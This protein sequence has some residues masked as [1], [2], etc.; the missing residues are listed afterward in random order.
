MSANIMSAGTQLSPEQ[1]TSL[2]YVT[3]DVPGTLGIVA[4]PNISK[5]ESAEAVPQGTVICVRSDAQLDVSLLPPRMFS[6]MALYPIISAK[7]DT[8]LDDAYFR[9]RMSG[10]AGRRIAAGFGAGP[11]LANTQLDGIGVPRGADRT[12]WKPLLG[13]GF[14]SVCKF[15]KE[16]YDS[17][18]YIAVYVPKTQLSDEFV[19]LANEIAQA[20]AHNL[21][22]AH[23][24]FKDI[25][26]LPE[27]HTAVR[28]AR[29]NAS[30]IAWSVASAF[31]VL[32]S[33][34]VDKYAPLSPS[35]LTQPMIAVPTHLSQYNHFDAVKVNT[36]NSSGTQLVDSVAIYN[37]CGSINESMGGFV[38]PVSPRVGIDLYPQLH[39]VVNF[40]QNKAVNAVPQ[41]RSVSGTRELRSADLRFNEHH[42]FWSSK[43]GKAVH[44]KMK[45]AYTVESDE[46]IERFL[47]HGASEEKMRL[48]HVIQY[49]GSA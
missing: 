23:S 28:L 39:R 32:I 47:P 48:S 24:T 2:E 16:L 9:S 27:Y 34:Q 26:E 22:G 41:G 7:G 14:W 11:S 17:Q 31:E 21:A 29:R 36:K 37:R 3:R 43:R 49:L 40:V 19:N 15:E 46:E 13:T 18:Y 8:D 33:H 5:L 45:R 1:R 12:S 35:T 6:V 42:V 44:P 20:D 4:M 38:M 10:E 25:H 30:K